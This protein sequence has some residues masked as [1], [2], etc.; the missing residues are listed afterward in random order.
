[1][2]LTDYGLRL[3]VPDG[4]WLLTSTTKPWAQR[5]IKLGKLFRLKT[6]LGLKSF[7]T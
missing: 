5:G 6:K 1:M 3:I 4:N 2:K 7:V